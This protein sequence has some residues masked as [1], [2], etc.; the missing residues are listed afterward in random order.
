MWEDETF[1]ANG[2]LVHNCRCLLTPLSP[3]EVDEMD[4]PDKEGP[5]V[6]A[7][8]GWGSPPSS[9]GTDWAADDSLPG[10]LKGALDDLIDR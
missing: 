6:D 3:D 8:E 2:I 1:V 7:D 9:E 5:D 10:P 4:G